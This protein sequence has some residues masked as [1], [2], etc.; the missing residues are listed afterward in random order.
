MIKVLLVEDSELVRNRIRRSLSEIGNIEIVGEAVNAKDA[1]KL[2]RQYKPHV[3]ILDIKLEGDY[4]GFY[5]LEELKVI[6]PSLKTIVLTNSQ[7]K[8]YKTKAFQL[9][10]DYFFDKSIEFDNV[11]KLFKRA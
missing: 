8:Q 2:G 1:I 6:H 4:N 10:A 7:E 5:A 11:L 3:M 9:G